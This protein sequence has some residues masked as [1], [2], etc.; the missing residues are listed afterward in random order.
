M[1][2]ACLLPLLK[3]GWRLYGPAPELDQV[4]RELD[5]RQRKNQLRNQIRN[6]ARGRAA[7]RSG[8]HGGPF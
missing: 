7:R 4:E 5:A 3:N 6:D 8:R 1:L 2:I